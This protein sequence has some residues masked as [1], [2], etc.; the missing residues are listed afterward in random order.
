MLKLQ[1]IIQLILFL[2]KNAIYGITSDVVKIFPIFR[3]CQFRCFLMIETN[4]N[5]AKSVQKSTSY[6]H[7]SKQRSVKKVLFF[8]N[9]IFSIYIIQ[10]QS[11]KR[12]KMLGV[13][14]IKRQKKRPKIFYKT[15][16]CDGLKVFGDPRFPTLDSQMAA[17]VWTQRSHFLDSSSV[18]PLL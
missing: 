17:S 13:S 8:L 15:Q 12:Q 14:S 6:N 5:L 1:V 18:E 3:A 2:E 10:R 4:H 7:L 11:M 16:T 9:P